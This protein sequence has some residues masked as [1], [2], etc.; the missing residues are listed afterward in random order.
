[1][2]KS[3]GILKKS[4]LEEKITY[5]VCP[6]LTCKLFFCETRTCPCIFECPMKEKERFLFLCPFC[7][8]LIVHDGYFI[9]IS[10]M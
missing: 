4:E 7:K 3:K 1:M 9:H 6:D 5:I 10:N 8:G 2:K